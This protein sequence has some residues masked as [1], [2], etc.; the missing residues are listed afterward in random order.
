MNNQPYIS[1]SVKSI[2]VLPFVNMSAD[3]DNEYFSDG[4][5]EEIINALTTIKGL[6]V[7]ARTSSFSFKH[8]NIDVRTIGRQLGVSTVLEGSVRKAKSRVRITAQ[9]ISTQDGTHFWSKNF[10]RELED[11]FALQDE[12]SLLIADQIRENFGHFD[13]QD[14]LIGAP[15]KNMDA[16]NLYLKGRYHQ[17]KWNAKDL[18]A[19]VDYYEQS[20][21]QDPSFALP[22]F[23]AALSYGINASWGFIPYNQGVQRAAELLREGLKIN[24][25]AYLGHF[26][27][28][29]VYFWGRWDFKNGHKHFS[30]AISINPAFTDA[31]E[32]LAELYTA[33]GA[34]KKAFHHTQNILN[35]NPLSPNHY[36]TEG[37]I[38]YLSGDYEKAIK[39]LETGLQVDPEFAL[40]TE[41][42][43]LCYIHLKD[44][45]RLEEFLRDHPQAQHPDKCKALFKLMHPDVAQADVDLAAIRTQIKEDNTASLIAWNLYL[46]VYLGK[47]ERALDALEKRLE[48]KTGQLINF[49]YDPLLTPLHSHERFQKLVARIFHPSRLPDL[50]SE[51]TTNI[52]S[53]RAVIPANEVKSY[54]IAITDSLEKERVFLDPALSLKLLA[55]HVNLHPNKLSWLLNEHIG[56]NFNEYINT[57]RLEAFKAKALDPRNSHLTLLGLAYESGFNSKSV[58]NA[59]FKKMEGVTPRAWVKSRQS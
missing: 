50:N 16:Y 8:K 3:P 17:L 40:A 19:G 43:A 11:I 52:D 15:T 36:Y 59:F 25:Q 58:F 47:H 5:T 18:L 12:V 34:F 29:T 20:I 37:N 41:M 31:E 24:D 54:L 13:I 32:G 26:A 9:L 38:H 55:E 2:V 30:Q 1:N 39:S 21:R 56:K 42:I 6:K 23:G 28:A 57:Y 14:Q 7:I 4:I 35:I 10:D 46:Q 53:I 48:A 27:Q 33:I 51:A 22:Y 49:K 44:Y 45:N